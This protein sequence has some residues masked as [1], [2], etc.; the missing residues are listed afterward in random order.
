MHLPRTARS[1]L[2]GQRLRKLRQD[3]G[4]TVATVVAQIGVAKSTMG[5]IEGGEVIPQK[6]TLVSL[7]ALY[8]VTDQ[9]LTD[10]LALA[11]SSNSTGGWLHAFYGDLP[12]E[13]LDFVAFEADARE[14]LTFQTSL[15]PG[16]LQIEE[17]SRAVI[18]AGLLAATP[19]V[20]ERRVEVRRKRQAAM[21]RKSPLRLHAIIDE[22]ALSRVVGGPRLM[23]NQLKSMAKLPRNVRLQVVPFAAGAHPGMMG[24]FVYMKFAEV[25]ATDLVYIESSAGELYREDE[26]DLALFAG[27]FVNLT[28]RALDVGDSAAL[29][30]SYAKRYQGG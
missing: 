7:L 22:A 14:I 6:R 1:R 30:E 13:Y 2:L 28:S 8:G 20:V 25:D 3:L 4:L 24:P 18:E 17:Y 15:I 19:D 21:N 29:I 11:E 23:A 27:I 10:M 5:R 12:G 26:R 16:L 9:N